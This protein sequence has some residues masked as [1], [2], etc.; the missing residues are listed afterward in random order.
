MVNLY[1]ESDERL[2]HQRT[3]EPFNKQSIVY[4]ANLMKKSSRRHV[5]TIHVHFD[6]KKYDR[7]SST[8]PQMTS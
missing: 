6:L 1:K 5:I 4:F 7:L 3:V 8:I 2:M